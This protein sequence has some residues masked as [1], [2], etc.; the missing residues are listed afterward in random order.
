MTKTANNN[1]TGAVVFLLLFTVASI[2]MKLLN[3]VP[4]SW[5]LILSPLWVCIVLL[6]I[7]QI[8]Y[9]IINISGK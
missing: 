8:I 3:I 5:L 4:W 2:A 1:L 9:L 6:A 7:F